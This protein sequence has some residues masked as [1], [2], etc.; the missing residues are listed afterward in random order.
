MINVRVILLNYILMCKSQYFS[1]TVRCSINYNKYL[2]H[3]YQFIVRQSTT[4]RKKAKT[5]HA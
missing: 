3:M 2:L 5:L 1:S 4:K